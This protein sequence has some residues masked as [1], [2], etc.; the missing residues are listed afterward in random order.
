MERELKEKLSCNVS[1]KSLDKINKWEYETQKSMLVIQA[2]RNAKHMYGREINE[3]PNPNYS[4]THKISVIIFELNG[5]R[6]LKYCLLV[7][8]GGVSIGG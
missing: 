2:K 1:T 4:Y 3:R 8:Y 5:D 7:S 6:F